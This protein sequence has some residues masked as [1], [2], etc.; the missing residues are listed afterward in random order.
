MRAETTAESEAL[1]AGYTLPWSWYTDPGVYHLEQERLFRRSWQY[2]GRA[3]Q[4]LES[5]SYF[6]CRAGDAPIVVARARDGALNAFLNVCRHR[7]AE[8]VEGEGRRETLR[9]RYHAW[10]YGLDGSLRAVPR[11]DREQGFEAGELSLRRVA[12]DTWGPFVFVNP[13][14]G[15]APLAHTLRELPEIVEASG[16]ELSSLRFRVRSEYELEANWKVACENFLE[17]Y[18]CPVAHAGF[19][20]VVDVDP[21]SYRL[22]THETFAS[23]FGSVR[24]QPRRPAYDP[25]GE[26]ERGQ[27]HLLWP[28]TK[29]N[30]MPG[31]GNL[32]IGPVVPAGP[33]RTTGFLDYF[34]AE[35]ADEAWIDDL[36]AFDD[37]LGREDARL[38]ESVQRGV[39]SG[40]VER[41][42][43]LPRSERLIQ[44]FQRYVLDAL[45]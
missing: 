37:Q 38:V 39:R 41:G 16:I 27:F 28:N 30:L 6:T 42:R 7:G 36:L 35:D 20:D 23:Q 43:L 17:C 3:D 8:L 21:D 45:S 22:E 14:A 5:G 44:A 10:T 19:S 15:A 24:E 29:L 34:F 2:A 11:A 18:H 26:V 25:R 13:D 31:K 33:E 40:L 32:S 1:A 12:V 9:C 4:V